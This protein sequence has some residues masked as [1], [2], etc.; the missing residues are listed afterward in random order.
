MT[1]PPVNPSDEIFVTPDQLCIGLYV[2][3][4]LPWFSHPFSFNNFKIRSADQIA[5]LRSLN[6]KQFRVDAARSDEAA[7]PTTQSG[8]PAHTPETAPV[9]AAPAADPVSEENR[10]RAQRLKAR[11]QQIHNVEKAFTKAAA[12]MR[13]INRELVS[14]PKECLDEVGMLVDQMVGCFL[15][16]PEATLHAMGEKA[17][18]EEVYFHGLN[19]AVLA[20]MLAKEMNLSVE[21]SRL[22]GMGA[23]LHDIG[24]LEIPDRVLKKTEEL[25]HAER[26]LRKMHCEYGFR[27]GQKIG[28][29][30]DVLAIIMQHHE[31]ADGTGYPK[32]LKGDEIHFLARIVSMI[33][34]Y[35]NLCSP[36]DI[37][38][39]LTPHEALSLMFAQRRSKFDAKALQTLIRCL[40]VYPPGTLVKLS[41]EVIGL[42]QSINPRKPLRP[43][44]MIYDASVPK[45]EALMVDLEHETELNISA[46]LRPV[47]LPA[48]IHDYLS[49]R[50]RVTYYFDGDSR[51]GSSE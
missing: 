36:T 16:M 43:W 29:P 21:H 26:E 48:H 7:L 46:A 31:F 32:G 9:T 27:T 35:D 14:R 34:H 23:M 41:N 1:S 39:G 25:T 22:L 18:G 8:T 47:Q 12:I 2:H 49:P 11:H 6:Q 45:E 17:G 42:V 37:S 51:K 4:D 30:A 20:T 15:E 44:V 10:V 50:K 38:R 33:N 28:L 3:I 40:G 24:L 13:R 19:T 5:T